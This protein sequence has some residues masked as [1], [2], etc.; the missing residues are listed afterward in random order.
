MASVSPPPPG[1]PNAATVPPP[2]SDADARPRGLA[3]RALIDS[4]IC[5]IVVA[6]LSGRVL[7]AN[8]EFLRITGYSRDDVAAGRFDWRALTPPDQAAILAAAIDEITRT[9][10]C[11]PYETEYLRKDGSRI[12]VLIGTA[13][14]A[15][16]GAAQTGVGFVLDLSPHRALQDAVRR[17]EDQFK[18]FIEQSPLPTI[19][20]TPDGRIAHANPAWLRLFETTIEMT[21]WYN[22]FADP[23]IHRNGVMPLVERGFRVEPTL[24]PPIPYV[25]PAGGKA[26]Q[27]IWLGALVYPVK[28]ADGRV[29]RVIIVEEDVTEQRRAQE[30]VRTSLDRLQFVLDAA[31]LGD[32]SWDAKSDLV[33]LSPRAAE[34]F[35]VPPGAHLTRDQLSRRV[36]PEDHARARAA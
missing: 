27:V 34:F 36:D 28:D 7:D 35:G 22:V 15:D 23:E 5:G 8:D 6:D 20:A 17:S 1:E 12:P 19:I 16:A 11:A 14:V 33:T 21:R 13:P 29:E 4:P 9:G 3:E 31:R 18:R 32:W 30:Q 10:R 24:I 2:R 25:A 26:G